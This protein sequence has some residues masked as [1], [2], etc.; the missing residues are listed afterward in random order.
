MKSILLLLIFNFINNNFNSG[1]VTYKII[2][3]V[4]KEIDESKYPKHLVEEVKKIHEERKNFEF[5]LTFNEKKSRYKK[6]E[7]LEKK[8]SKEYKMALKT[9]ANEEIYY[10]SSEKT[11]I[12]KIS[13]GELIKSRNS[14]AWSTLSESKKIDNYTAYKA[15]TIVKYNSKGV[16]KQKTIIAWYCPELPY[17]YGP[18]E[19]TGLPGLILELNDGNISYVVKKINLSKNKT[20]IEIPK[21]K[22]MSEEEYLK[23]IK[24]RFGY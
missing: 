19:Y 17:N 10:D 1:E 11:F 15:T 23:K 22:T 2:L 3:P 18:L 14:I 6:I 21:G 20:V 8:E 7:T 13:S 9:F 5:I 12:K 16:Q 24:E 4:P